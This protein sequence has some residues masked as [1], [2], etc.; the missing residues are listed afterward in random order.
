MS[1]PKLKTIGAFEKAVN[2]FCKQY[3][4]PEFELQEDNDG[5]MIVYTNIC[6]DS[7]TGKLDYDINTG[8]DE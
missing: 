7:E 6:V 1:K 4:M 3:N 2:K 5:F 8:D